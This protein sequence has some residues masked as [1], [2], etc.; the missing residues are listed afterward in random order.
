MEGCYTA[1]Q[2]S[3][4]LSLSLTLSLSLG[5]LSVFRKL[6]RGAGGRVVYAGGQSAQWPA[7]ISQWL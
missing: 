4:S 3:L 1:S 2:H 7:T 6:G 5:L